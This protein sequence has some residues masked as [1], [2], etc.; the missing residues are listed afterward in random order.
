MSPLFRPACHAAL[1]LALL[2]TS[3]WISAKSVA[4]DGAMAVVE[5]MPLTIKHEA[6]LGLS[7]DQINALSAYR[8]Q[9][10]PARLR[11]QEQILDLRA[12]LRMAILDNK[13]QAERAT[14][15]ERIAVAETAPFQGRS[16]C[17]DQVRSILTATQFAQL[18][19][20]YLDGLR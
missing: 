19:Q 14:L 9:A 16:R 18:R 5:L 15:M 7:S 3:G 17:V 11:L 10:M 2:A 20:R 4:G 12:Q 1:A 13:M 8:K 6:D